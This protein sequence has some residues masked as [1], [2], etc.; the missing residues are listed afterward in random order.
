MR[1]L[2]STRKQALLPVGAAVVVGILAI[3]AGGLPEPGFDRSWLRDVLIGAG[4]SALLFVP[5]YFLTRSLDG[6]LSAVAQQSTR[7]AEELSGRVDALREEVDQRLGAMSERVST[8][9]QDENEA[10]LAAFAGVTESPTR[11][12]IARALSLAQNARLID[13]KAP[14][15][16]QVDKYERLYV[17]FTYYEGSRFQGQD[18]ND[19]LYLELVT[20]DGA[21]VAGS[22]LF[23]WG[24]HQTADEVLTDVGRALWR[25]TN[26]TLDP[27]ALIKGLEDLL[28]T[29]AASPE[30][31]PAVVACTPEWLVVGG[32]H[33]QV[34]NPARE[35]GCPVERLHQEPSF[36]AHVAE[37]TWVNADA[38]DEVVE[39]ARSIFPEASR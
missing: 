1:S 4:T 9:L 11:E 31:R 20:Q 12:G 36:R 38:W 16:V 26:G 7:T 19:Q 8:R 10:M 17:T 18:L 24:A 3:G 6:H 25:C 34:I 29:A 28:Q 33:P 23:V 14:P 27:E 32:S 22:H 5:F 30:L 39:V 37:K 2:G 13:H 21:T 15:R 35:Y